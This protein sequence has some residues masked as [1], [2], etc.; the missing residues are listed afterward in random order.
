MGCYL[1][2][3]RARV[4]TWAGR[5]SWRSVRGG[6]RFGHGSCLGNTILC[7]A[8]LAV[9]LIIS[10]VEQNPGPGSEN[11][12]QVLCNVCDRNLKSGTQCDT[13]GRWFHNSCGNV[14]AHMVESGRWCCD[15]CRWDRLRQLEEKL[16]NALHQIE[17]LKRQN[18][19]LEEQLRGA[20]AGCEVSGRD[21][22]QKLQGG[23][24][25]LVLGDSII[26]DVGTDHG[27]IKVECFPGIRTEQLQRVMENRN[28]GNPDTVIIHVGT[29]DLRRTANLD[30]VMGDVYA[31]VQ[32]AR[33]KFPISKL[34]LS[35]VLRRRDVSWRR[36]GALNDRYDW[37]ARTT[38]VTFVDPN[39]WIDD[40][41]FSRDRLHINRGGAKRLGKLYHRV[42]G[43]DG[44][45]QKLNE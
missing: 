30:Y 45:G 44:G 15:R 11:I 20:A 24:E 21:T 19:R 9:L 4:G 1:E 25:C 40:R 35:G 28:F 38:G 37:V 8:A 41:D 10:G 22:A 14:K 6:D 5:T 26:R 18:K 7:A 32:K 13:C 27:N 33:T 39:S 2:D 16:E 29:N 36:I 3:Y 23:A 43:F 42:C 17:D 31:L 34:V 12:L